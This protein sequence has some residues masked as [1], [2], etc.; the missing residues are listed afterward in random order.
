MSTIPTAKERMEL[1]KVS[2]AKHI[3]FIVLV[4]LI[5]IASITFL[6]PNDTS[7]LVIVFVGTSICLIG[8]SSMRLQ[9]FQRCPRCSGR[10]SRRAAVCAGCGLEYHA[11]ETIK[12]KKDIGT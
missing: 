2:R 10:M 11:S 4:V 5:C 7:P 6:F 1:E 9:Y 8:A 3:H 12:Q